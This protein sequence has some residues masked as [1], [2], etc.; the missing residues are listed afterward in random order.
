MTVADLL[1]L[2]G[3]AIATSLV[4]SLVKRMWQPDP[5][6]LDRFGPAI[7]ILLGLMLGGGAA[8]SQQ[9]DIA[10]AAINGVL[11]G[12]SAMG[13]YDIASRTPAAGLV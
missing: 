2:G 8:L 5:D 1:T 4:F 9:A 12:L 6:T 10:Q 13:M 11:A 7:A 3:L